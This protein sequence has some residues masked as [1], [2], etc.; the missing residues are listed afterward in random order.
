[1]IFGLNKQVV[2]V[3]LRFSRFLA[4]KC[5]SLNDEPCM[6]RPTPLDWNP[7]ELKYYSF[8]IRLDKCNGNWKCFIPKNMCFQK[9][10]K[11]K[12]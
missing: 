1:M 7:V 3:L 10:K 5:G 6:I 11:N 12:Y 8:M 2:I 4:T 9:Y